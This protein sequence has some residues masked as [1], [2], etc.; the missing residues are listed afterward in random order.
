MT[1]TTIDGAAVTKRA[2]HEISRG[3]LKTALLRTAI[4]LRLFDTLADG[5]EVGALAPALSVDERALRI[6]L[7]GLTAIGLLRKDGTR[8]LLAPGSEE[9]LL[10]SSPHYF[11][12]AVRLGASDWEWDAQRRLTDAVRKGGT[13]LEEHYLT[14]ELAYWEDF[15]EHTTWF[16]N[17]AADVLADQLVPWAK[18]RDGVDVLDVAASHGAYG[19]SFARRE[20]RARIWCL[21]WPNVLTHTRRNAERFGLTDRVNV[22]PGDMFSVPL[23]GPYDI[24]LVTNVLHHFTEETAVRLMTRISTAVKPG[25]RVVVVGHTFREGEDP[26][27]NPMPFLFSVSMLAQTHDGETHSVGAYQRILEASGFTGTRLHTG[28]AAQHTV[29]IAEKS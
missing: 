12:G 5:A 21:D 10:S 17:G 28:P 14:P 4:D 27:Q 15:A 23:G 8:Y 29:F 11:G 22:I 24:A 7:D 13:V 19:F 18:G 9:F 20:P 1:T 26:R 3:Y 25:G 16:N 2:L 6:V